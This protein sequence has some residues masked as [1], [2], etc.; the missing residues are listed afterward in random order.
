MNGLLQWIAMIFSTLLA[1][2]TLT[3]IVFGD[4]VPYP[5]AK[6]VVPQWA[7]SLA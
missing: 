2:M 4:F 1:R 3:L 6:R 5:G 7:V